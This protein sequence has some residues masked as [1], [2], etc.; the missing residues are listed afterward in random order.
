MTDRVATVM[1]CPSCDAMIPSDSEACPQCGYDLSSGRSLG[2]LVHLTDDLS[3]ITVRSF[4]GDWEIRH[5]G[6]PDES[7]TVRGYPV[8]FNSLSLDLGGFKEQIDPR[9]F[10]EVLASSPDVHFVWD[11]DTRYVGARTRNG[12]LALNVD[13]R[14]VFM[15]A[16]VGNYSWAK[17]LRLSLERGDID[18]GSFKFTVGDDD[19][20]ADG[21]GNITRTVRNVS[22]L[23]DVTVTAQGAYPQTSMAVARSLI[24]SAR[25]AGRLPQVVMP[26]N[27]ETFAAV[28]P[29]AEAELVAERGESPSQPGGMDAEDA[30]R[31]I[32][33]LLHRSA[34]RKDE[35]KA[36][37]EKAG[38]LT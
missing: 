14:G 6:R 23:Y 16:Q 12:T 18:Q 11:H 36:L 5:S 38:K 20:D 29:L 8:V 25:A 35:L 13:H 26:L 2:A 4:V 37:I 17:D 34:V 27:A 9:A 28:A 19:W 22:G 24:A 7:F 30:A 3:T 1:N 31:T 32:S 21:E 33:E 15:D 10:D